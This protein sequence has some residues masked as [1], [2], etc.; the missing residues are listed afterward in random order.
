MTSSKS[1]GIC[2]AELTLTIRDGA[3]L[4]ISGRSRRVSR[5]GAR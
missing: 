2:P 3:E 5:N 4:L 1:I